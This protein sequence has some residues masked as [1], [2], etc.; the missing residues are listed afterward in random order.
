VASEIEEKSLTLV[1]VYGWIDFLCL[2]LYGKYKTKE[3]KSPV[4]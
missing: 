4:T 1:C 3:G 2:N